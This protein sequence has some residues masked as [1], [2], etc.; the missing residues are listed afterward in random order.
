MHRRHGSPNGTDRPDLMASACSIA[1]AYVVIH[2][3]EQ[4]RDG[5]CVEKGGSIQSNFSF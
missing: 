4:P 2:E 1:S 3:V 5:F